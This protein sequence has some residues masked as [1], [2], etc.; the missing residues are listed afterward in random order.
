M[1]KYEASVDAGCPTFLIHESLKRAAFGGDD[2]LSSLIIQ[3]TGL[4]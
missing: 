2:L 1:S 3:R 4:V